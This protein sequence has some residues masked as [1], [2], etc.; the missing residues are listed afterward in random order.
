VTVTPVPLYEFTEP[1]VGCAAHSDPTCLCD[2]VIDRRVAVRYR[3]S[4]V[5]FGDFAARLT[6]E[7]QSPEDVAPWAARVLS[8]Y[9]FARSVRDGVSQWPTTPL[10]E[11]SNVAALKEARSRHVEHVRA[12][13]TPK[14]PHKER[15]VAACALASWGLPLAEVCEASFLSHDYVASLYRSALRK[16]WTGPCGLYD[17]PAIVD[18][19]ISGVPRSEIYRKHDIGRSFLAYLTSTC[20]AKRAAIPAMLATSDAVIEDLKGLSHN[21]RRIWRLMKKPNMTL[22][23]VSEELG[24]HYTWVAQMWEDAQIKMSAKYSQAEAS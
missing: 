9:D 17:F 22:Q 6:G 19:Y 4:Q 23:R 1:S 20:G 16:E 18:D 21:Q 14:V 8:W 24:L 15:R 5:L 3:P 12:R 10:T 2:V 11:L 13:I 7:P